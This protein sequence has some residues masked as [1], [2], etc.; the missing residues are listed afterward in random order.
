MLVDGRRCRLT[1]GEVI[2]LRAKKDFLAGDRRAIDRWINYAEKVEP[3]LSEDDSRLLDL[4]SLTEEQL[5]AI[6]S[7]KFR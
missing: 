1:I 4:D 6:A 3:H 2:A 7:I 5:R